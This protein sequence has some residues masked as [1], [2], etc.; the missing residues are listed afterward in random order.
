MSSTTFV[1]SVKCLGI[2]PRMKG[3]GTFLDFCK[4]SLSILTAKYKRHQGLTY[5]EEG[6]QFTKI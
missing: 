1:K 3:G 2:E 4:H 5:L 6:Y